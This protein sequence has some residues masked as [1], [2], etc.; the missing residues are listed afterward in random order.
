[1]ARSVGSG[2]CCALCRQGETLGH[3][4]WGCQYAKAVW[5]GTKIK[6]PWLQDPLN[7]FV[8]IIWE[9]MN[10]HSLVDWTMFVMTAWSIWNNR[11]TVIHKG[12]CKGNR[13]LIRAVANYVDEIKQK[14]QPQLR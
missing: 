2:D 14:K 7:D 4:L 8:D 3:I 1:M 11:N 13:V 6:L 12:K 10:S 5:C 9:T